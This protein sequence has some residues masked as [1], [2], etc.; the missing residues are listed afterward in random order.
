MSRAISSASSQGSVIALGEELSKAVERTERSR[1]REP[2]RER[3]VATEIQL[4]VLR[5]D[6]VDTHFGPPARR[7][8]SQSKLRYSIKLEDEDEEEMIF[9]EPESQDEEDNR[10]SAPPSAFIAHRLA[11][12][13]DDPIEKPDLPEEYRSQE[14]LENRRRANEMAGEST[15]RKEWSYIGGILNGKNV[16]TSLKEN[17]DVTA[18][19]G[20][21]SFASSTSSTTTE[22]TIHNSLRPSLPFNSSESTPSRTTTTQF[23]SPLGQ[24]FHPRHPLYNHSNFSAPSVTELIKRRE[25][26]LPPPSPDF[27]LRDVGNRRT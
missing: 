19:E 5:D 1:D 18:E 26:L 12:L 13:Y 25:G 15:A 27:L 21:C 7:S 4:D 20:D 24:P 17:I 11:H 10:R 6:D 3:S 14:A 23:F 2:L 16:L 22:D 9:V 8:R